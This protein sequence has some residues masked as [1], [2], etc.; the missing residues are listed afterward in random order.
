MMGERLVLNQM[1][2][3]ICSEKQLLTCSQEQYYAYGKMIVNS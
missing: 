1:M 2:V 3:A